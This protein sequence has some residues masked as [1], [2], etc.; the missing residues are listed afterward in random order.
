LSKINI[1]WICGFINS[2]GSF[3]VYLIQS[4]ASKFGFSTQLKIV[5][6]QHNKSLIVLDAI[7][8]YFNIGKIYSTSATGTV[9]DYK[10]FSL[11]DILLFIDLFKNTQLLGAKALDYTDFCTIVG[12]IQNKEHLT[13]EG[14][15]TIKEISSNMNS[16]RTQFEK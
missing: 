13:L 4:N 12:L 3:G 2:D 14:I 8:N 7:R 6:S 10:L 9:S 16:T 5:I 15:K 1:H 11:K